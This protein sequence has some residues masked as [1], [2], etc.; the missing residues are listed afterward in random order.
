MR[1]VLPPLLLF[2]ALA[3]LLLTA[4]PSFTRQSDPPSSNH[5]AA[6]AERLVERYLAAHQVPGLAI[7]VSVK[8][9][10]VWSEGF[11]YADVEQRVP[12]WP[13]TRFRIASLSKPLTAAAVAQL[14][15]QGRL[16]VDAPVQRYVPSFPKKRALVTTRQLGGHLAGVRHYRDDEYHIRNHYGSVAEALTIFAED[17]L[18]FE[19]GAQYAYSSYGWNLI[20]AVVEGAS[21]K[22][23]LEYMRAHVF[24]PLGMYHTVADHVDSLIAQRARFYVRTETGTLI[25][26][27]YVDNSYKWAGG[28][29]LSTTEDLLR[30]ANAHLR[31]AFFPPEVHTLLFTE[32]RTQAGEGVGYGFGWTLRTDAAGRPLVFHTGG[33]VGGTALLAV[34]PDTEVVLALLINLS[35]ADLSVGWD[36]FEHFVAAAERAS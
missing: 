27:P 28:G 7:A 25:N 26:A 32:Q 2:A 12:V 29:F 14:Y 1:H 13:S 33:A 24:R 8:G 15:A 31:S 20:S 30:F 22:P 21:G 18:L 23:F 35:D 4:P 10:T 34:H 19:P 36:V 6:A 17:T 16:D 5:Q 11:G 3:T 9:E